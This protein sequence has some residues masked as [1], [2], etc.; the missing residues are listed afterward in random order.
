M[1]TQVNQGPSRSKRPYRITFNVATGKVGAIE[2]WNIAWLDKRNRTRFMTCEEIW[3]PNIK[4]TR[5]GAHAEGVGYANW[6]DTQ[7][8]RVLLITDEADSPLPRLF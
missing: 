5:G 3:A 1:R 4:F 8:G 6:M 2:R 7:N